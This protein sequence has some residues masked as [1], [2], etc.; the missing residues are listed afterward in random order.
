MAVLYI[1]EYAHQ[2][3]DV[4][5]QLIPAGTEP[6]LASQTV[7]IGVAAQSAAFNAKTKFVRLHCDAICSVK[8]GSNPTAT[9]SDARMAANST[10]FFGLG[11]TGLKLSVISNT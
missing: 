2:A 10:E 6:P 8:F 7:A 1:T 5:G 11:E 9:T 4:N 3:K